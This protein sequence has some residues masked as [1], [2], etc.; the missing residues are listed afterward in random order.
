MGCYI[1]GRI[2]IILLIVFHAI[3]LLHEIPLHK[4]LHIL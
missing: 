1:N 2:I 3:K 4:K